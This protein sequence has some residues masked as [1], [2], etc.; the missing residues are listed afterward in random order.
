MVPGVVGRDAVRLAAG[1]LMG[2]AADFLV[3]RLG[4]YLQVQPV[5]WGE[6][7]RG[8][9]FADH[10]LELQHWDSLVLPSSCLRSL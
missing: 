3:A 8:E 2:N 1:C 4:A 7:V 10:H 5:H 9:K 6:L